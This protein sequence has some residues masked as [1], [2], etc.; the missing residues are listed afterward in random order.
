M[1]PDEH[2]DKSQQPGA[3]ELTSLFAF[4][5]LLFTFFGLAVG[6][7]FVANDYEQPYGIIA[8]VLGISTPAF[9]G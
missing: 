6:F 9:I 8:A 3:G 4:F 2:K 7:G 5:I 1:N